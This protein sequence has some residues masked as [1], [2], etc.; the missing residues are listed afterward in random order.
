MLSL[1]RKKERKGSERAVVVE[2]EARKL[3]AF[4]E[5]TRLKGDF[6]SQVGILEDLI[7]SG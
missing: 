2:V 3:W 4:P 1:G 5:M 7:L 6:F